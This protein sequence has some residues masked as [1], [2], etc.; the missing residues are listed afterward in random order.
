[1][2]I[3]EMGKALGWKLLCGAEEEDALARE[4]DG[5]YVG[6]LLSW[7]MSRARSGNVWLTVMG[8]IYAIGVAALADVSAI[9]L[10]EDSALDEQAREK[11]ELQGILVY[12]CSEPLFET[13]VLVHGLLAP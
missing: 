7:V 6:D 2:T 10:A 3:E 5:C 12:S 11:A 13:A 1:M 9:V 4:V 8:N